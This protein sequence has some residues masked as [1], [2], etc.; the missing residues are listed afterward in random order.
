MSEPP[1]EPREIPP[2]YRM[3]NGELVPAEQPAITRI[4]PTPKDVRRPRWPRRPR[5]SWGNIP[6]YWPIVATLG[7]LVLFLAVIA[8]NSPDSVPEQQRHFLTIVKQGQDAV[9][10]GNDITLV[11]ASRQRA[12]DTC[13]LLPRDLAVTDWI[14]TITDVGTV[15]GGEAGVLRVAIGDDVEVKTWTDEG[16]DR[17]DHTLIDPDSSVY[18][19]LSTLQEGN[20]IRFSGTFVPRP[21]TCLQETSL[22]ARNGMLTPDFIFRFTSVAPR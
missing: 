10:H 12:R 9:R 11:T 22:F 7:A 2:G 14:G 17:R 5:R 13:S 3:Q 4:M 19:S 16:D 20:G 15:S 21:G 8:F 18:H 1:R 6:G